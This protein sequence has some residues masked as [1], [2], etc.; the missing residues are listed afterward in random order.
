MTGAR[1]SKRIWP[2]L[3]GAAS[4]AAVAAQKSRAGVAPTVC[5]AVVMSRTAFDA[6]LHEMIELR[7]LPTFVAFVDG[8]GGKRKL[9]RSAWKMVADSRKSLR[10]VTRSEKVKFTDIRESSL[11]EK[12]QTILLLLNVELRSNIVARFEYK[13]ESLLLLN[14]LR[15][16][17]VHHNFSAPS[18]HLLSACQRISAKVNLPS[19]LSI[20]PWEDILSKP[21][22]GRWACL[23]VARSIL[24]LEE[25]EYNRK[26]HLVACRDT[27]L[28]SISPLEL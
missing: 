11:I 5:T 3:L 16:A 8:T 14:T 23:S 1:T 7:D 13:F 2:T 17:I 12:L 4:Q 21:A 10:G 15:N 25:L 28:S 19:E 9:S 20:R 6:Y 18:D 24:S 26:I 22:I 27:I